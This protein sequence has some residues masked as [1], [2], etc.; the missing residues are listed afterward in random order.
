MGLTVRDG[1]TRRP[2][3]AGYVR[4][5][6]EMQVERGDSLAV[7]E[8]R[9]R[10]EAERRGWDLV[11]YREPGISAKDNNRPEFQRMMADLE[12]GRID[13]VVATKLDRLWRSTQLAVTGLNTIT[14][15]YGRELVILDAPFDSTTPAG[16]VMFTLMASLAA[17]ER[18]TTAERVLDSMKGR[19]EAGKFNGGPVP[20]GYRLE[21][22]FLVPD[23]AEAATIRRM[24]EL[25]LL[26]P[27]I[28]QVRLELDRTG[29]RTRKGYRWAGETL[30]RLLASPLYVGVLVYNQRTVKSGKAKAV[31]ADEHIRVEGAVPAIIDRDTFDRVQA[32]LAAKPLA[33]RTQ[34]SQHLLSGLVRC[35]RCGA[36]M[37][38]QHVR[39]QVKAAKRPKRQ[40]PA[41]VEADWLDEVEADRNAA[42]QN[43]PVVEVLQYFGCATR[44]RRDATVCPGNLVRADVLE[45]AVLDAL[46]DLRLNPER[47]RALETQQQKRRRGEVPKLRQDVA[48]LERKAGEMAGR[49]DRILSAFESGAYDAAKMRERLARV[50]EEKRVVEQQLAD[51]RERLAVAE[52]QVINVD[53]VLVALTNAYE[54][55]DT[56]SFD[57]RRSMLRALVDRVVVEGKAGGTI[58][59]R[60]DVAQVAGGLFE[61][62]G[63]GTK[64]F[65]LDEQGRVPWLPAKELA[66]VDSNV[67]SVQQRTGRGSS[68]RPA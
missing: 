55:F 6:T 49:E 40:S 1:S 60:T 64:A 36:G 14:Q 28:R 41:E 11:V 20:Y 48:R 24:F 9:L 39:R 57:G 27:S 37:H 33:P 68:R 34:G 5:S 2:L 42:L 23:E 4:V 7:Q 25:A 8:A 3:M 46:F 45:R 26:K 54:V 58:H 21:G 10:T 44:S 51:S 12:A 30:R 43:N 61:T 31:P 67:V 32:K 22:A 65:R 52:R 63:S 53:A 62:E 13:G 19:A 50:G 29:S 18:E 15:E 38:A 47:L 56:L 35:G 16:R 17:F 66:E 59:L